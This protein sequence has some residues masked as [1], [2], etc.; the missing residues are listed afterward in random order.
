YGDKGYLTSLFE[1]LLEEGLHLVTK[2]RRNMKNMLLTLQD[3]LNLLKRGSI[4]AVND[5][6]MRSL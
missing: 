5:I 3:K 4:E 2:V 6:L 1:E